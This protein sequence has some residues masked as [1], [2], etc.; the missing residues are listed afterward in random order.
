[1][2]SADRA[3]VKKKPPGQSC[4][5]KWDKRR[6]LGDES[7]RA[8]VECFCHFVRFRRGL[9]GAQPISTSALVLRPAEGLPRFGQRAYKRLRSKC[10]P[11]EIARPLDRPRHCSLLFRDLVCAKSQT[12]GQRG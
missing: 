4:L 6:E 7:G 10:P 2:R 11:Y 3:C 5:W 12:G 9:T 1:M 8:R